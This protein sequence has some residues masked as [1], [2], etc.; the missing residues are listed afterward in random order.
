MAVAHKAAGPVV[1]PTHASG[2]H[3]SRGF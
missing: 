1:A 3:A 2:G